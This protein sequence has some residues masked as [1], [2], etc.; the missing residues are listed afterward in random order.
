LL[1]A[2]R[3]SYCAVAVVPAELL[4]LLLA[5]VG[6][7]GGTE[8][9]AVAAVGGVVHVETVSFAGGAVQQQRAAVASV[10]IDAVVGLMKKQNMVIQYKY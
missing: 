9:V 4:L 10:A 5:A 1:A 8:T 2:F 6:V 7:A 3:K